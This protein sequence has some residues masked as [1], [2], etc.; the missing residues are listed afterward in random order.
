ME[1]SNSNQLTTS[2]IMAITVPIC[3]ML[4]SI[5]WAVA[6][7]LMVREKYRAQVEVVAWEHEH[8]KHK[9]KK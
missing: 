5:A 6:S 2:Q 3:A 7:Y 1:N 8:N 9:G 4:A